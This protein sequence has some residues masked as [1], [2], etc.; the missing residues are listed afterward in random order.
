[1]KYEIIYPDKTK[2]MIENTDLDFIRGVIGVEY[3]RWK[4]GW[5]KYTPNDHPI[6]DVKRITNGKRTKVGSVVFYK[7]FPVWLANGKAYAYK[8]NG[9]IAEMIK[10]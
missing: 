4:K 6:F 9:K 10:V 8:R 1:M 5:D 2:M 7:A 3:M